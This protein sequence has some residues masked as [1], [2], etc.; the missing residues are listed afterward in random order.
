MPGF[1]PL[2]SHDKAGRCECRALQYKLLIMSDDSP[3]VVSVWRSEEGTHWTVQIDT[4]LDT[5]PTAVDLNEGRVF[6]GDPERFDPVV[7]AKAVLEAVGEGQ[8][9]HDGTVRAMVAAIRGGV[10]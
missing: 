1:G 6:F 4:T 2:H 8:L 7:A 10:R 9:L 5:G 3:P